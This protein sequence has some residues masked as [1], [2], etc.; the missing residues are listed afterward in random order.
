MQLH[1]RESLFLTLVSG[2]DKTSLAHAAYQ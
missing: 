1:S 2:V